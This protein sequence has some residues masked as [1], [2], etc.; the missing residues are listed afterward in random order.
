VSLNS[1]INIQIVLSATA[2]SQANFGVPAIFA[3]NLPS[4]FQGVIQYYDSPEAATTP[5]GPFAATHPAI[6]AANA[7]FDQEPTVTQFAIARRT[8]LPL[9]T[10]NL[11]CS[12]ANAADVYSF[13]V[14][15]YDGVS[16][17][18]SVPSTGVPAT[19]AAT[20]ATALGAPITNIGTVSHTSATVTLTQSGG[21][22]VNLLNWGGTGAAGAPILALT[23]ATADPGIA[24]DLAAV[25][26]VDQGWYGFALDSNSAAEIS[27]AAAWAEANGPVVFC[28]SNSDASDETSGSS[29]AK[30]LKTAAYTRTLGIFSGS[31]LLSYSG[32]A[33]LGKIL[34][35]TPGSYTAAYKTLSGVPADPSSILT[36]TVVN[37]LTANNFNY[38]TTFKGVNVVIS[39][40][41]PSGEFLDTVIGIDWLKDAIQ[42][43]LFTLLVQNL[44]IGY[45]D[46]GVQTCVNVIKGVL[47][48]GIQNGL[49]AK[50]PKPVVTAPLVAD[51]AAANVAQRNLPNVAFSATLDGAIQGLTVT[52]SVVLP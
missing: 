49:L 44:K 11:L 13:T 15:G 29:V 39:G 2:P 26:A 9:Q 6:L 5:V 30:T 50:S 8:L 10:L 51:V 3:G 37:N 16:H 12:S 7:I 47:K 35:L 45:D 20:I 25:R 42:T 46:D 19:D 14:V 18:I 38:Y 22:L 31:E 40:V 36:G 23:D 43:A 28:T 33:L 52:G 17:P 21:K 4:G 32:A 41:T 34:P 48:L 27:A 24:T 1:L